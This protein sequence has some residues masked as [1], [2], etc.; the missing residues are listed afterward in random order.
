M[1]SKCWPRLPGFTTSPWNPTMNP[2]P[3]PAE[4]PPK[5]RPKGPKERWRMRKNRALT[6]LKNQ[7]WS[8][9]RTSPKETWSFVCGRQSH[10][11]QVH[12]GPAPSKIVVKKLRWS[13]SGHRGLR[14]PYPKKAYSNLTPTAWRTTSKKKPAKTRRTTSLDEAINISQWR[15]W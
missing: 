9:C 15:Q 11:K 8:E 4:K 7:S 10:P 1:P 13:H 2:S 3:A 6:K 5:R 14:S 12:R